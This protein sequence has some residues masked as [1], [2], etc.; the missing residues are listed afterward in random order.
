MDSLPIYHMLQCENL[1]DAEHM[2]WLIINHVTDLIELSG[3]SPVQDF[4]SAIHRNPAASSLF[5]QA[6]HA[7]GQA[8]CQVS[9]KESTICYRL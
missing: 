9:I 1:S 7:R 8:V 3:E 5:I 4:I 2:T 6:I